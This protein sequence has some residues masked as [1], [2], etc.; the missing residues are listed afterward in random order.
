MSESENLKRCVDQAVHLMHERNLSLENENSALR[1]E[2]LE[3][4]ESINF[5]KQQSEFWAAE[6]I[7]EQ[8][9]ASISIIFMFLGC[10]STFIAIAT[11]ILS[12]Q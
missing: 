12:C 9:K 4:R 5:H 11:A 7:S 8:R 6:C 3:Q 10:S 2:S 1:L